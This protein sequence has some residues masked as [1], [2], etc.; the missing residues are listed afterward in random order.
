ML[1]RKKEFI[2]VEK[3]QFF[4][5]LVVLWLE[6]HVKWIILALTLTK[7]LCLVL[8]RPVE[9]LLKLQLHGNSFIKRAAVFDSYKYTSQ[10]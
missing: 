10:K 2:K 8:V 6:F 5:V 7:S 9:I 4:P 1:S 3:I